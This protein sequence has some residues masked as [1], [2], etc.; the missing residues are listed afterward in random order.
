MY[1]IN[2]NETVTAVSSSMD[3]IDRLSSLL[4]NKTGEAGA[5]VAS[6]GDC[7]EAAGRLEGVSVFPMAMEPTDE[8]A[9]IMIGHL[10]ADDLGSGEG[11]MKEILRRGHR[12]YAAM[13]RFDLVELYAG[14]FGGAKAPHPDA[15]VVSIVSDA[16]ARI[17]GSD[18]GAAVVMGSGHAVYVAAPRHQSRSAVA[19][20]GPGQK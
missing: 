18:N 9:E 2:D 11:H 15:R 17:L 4:K 19:C 8:D 10:I 12:G 13:C 1:L 6:V 5:A 16:I 7:R 20:Q 3:L 14:R